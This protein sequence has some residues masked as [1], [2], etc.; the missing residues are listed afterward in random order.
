M[1]SSLW[2]SAFA[3]HD[4]PEPTAAAEETWDVLLRMLASPLSREIEKADLPLWSP[5]RFEPAHRRR[6]HVHSVTLLCFDVDEQPIPDEAAIRAAIV[7]VQAVVHS[8]SRATATAPRWRLAFALSRPVTG[9]EYDRLWSAVRASLPFKVGNAARDPSRGW[10]W[11][12]EGP[13]GHYA[14]FATEGAP[15]DVEA[16]LARAPEV[17][18]TPAPAAERPRAE[19]PRAQRVLAK[20]AGAAAQ[21]AASWPKE[22]RH[23]AQLALAGALKHDGWEPEEALE[24]LCAVTRAA[25]DEDRPKREK[26]IAHT[27]RTE[28]VTGWSTLAAHVDATIVDDVRRGLNA[29]ADDMRALRRELSGPERVEEIADRVGRLSPAERARRIGDGKLHRLVTGFPSLDAATRGGLLLRKLVAVG[30][31]PGAGKTAFMIALG[32][33]WLCAGIPVAILA[34]DEDADALLIRLGQLGG[35]SREALESG[36]EA[37]RDALAAWCERVPLILADGDDEDATIERISEELQ[38]AARTPDG[39]GPSVFLVD[40]MQTVR[41]ETTPQ[42]DADARARVNHTVRALKR[43]SKVDGHLTLASSELSKAA[44]RN[45]AQAENVNLLSAFKESGDIEYGVALALALVS[46]AGTPDMVDAMVVKNRLG[47]GKPE[48]LFRLDAERADVSEASLVEITKLDPLFA[49]K[50]SILA[51][52]DSGANAP[53]SRHSIYTAFTGRNETKV[54]AVNELLEAGTL[55]HDP[56]EGIRRPLPGEPGYVER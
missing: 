39:Q 22:G 40:S 30:G 29:H 25:G 19:S 23:Q 2:L 34:A 33:R 10:Y 53:K 18:S 31:A 54:K 52:I 27:W 7:G 1:P 43:A 28:A 9:A 48:M 6:E 47:Q 55:F 13:D 49:V 38:T 45:R 44:Y 16:W 24:F 37:A 41:S 17:P 8:S 15:L 21:L 3:R 36:H 12:R 4:M 20:R 46:R 51:F 14:L 11:P 56:R 50:E 42:K 5:A 32:Y 26:T 35:L